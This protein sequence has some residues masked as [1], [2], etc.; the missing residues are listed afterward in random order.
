MMY[1]AT[2]GAWEWTL[3]TLYGVVLAGVVGRHVLCHLVVR[4]TTFLTPS[5]RGC[6]LRDAPKVSVLVP[7]KDEAANIGSC[8]NSLLA[9]HYPNFEVLVVDDRSTDETPAIVSGMAKRD[10]RLRLVRVKSLP[11]GW[12]GKCHALHFAQQMATGEWLLFIDADAT[13]HPDCLSVVLRDAIDADAGLASVLPRME[14]RSF[15]ERVVQPLAATFLM[16]LFPLPRVN[17]R[18]RSDYGFAN[19]QFLLMRRTAY[20]AIGGHEAVK[21][22][23]CEDINLGRLIKQKGLGL[24]VVVAPALASVRMYSSLSQIMRGW[25]RIF[26]AA[27]D[28]NAKYL[29]AFTAAFFLLSALPYLVIPICLAAILSGSAGPLAWTMLLMAIVHDVLQT[30]LYVRAFAAGQTPLRL[31]VWRPIAIGMMLAILLKTIR[32]CQ[33]HQVVWRGTQ[34]ATMSQKGLPAAVGERAK[35]A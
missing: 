17:D 2:L 34:Y 35:A 29:G 22:K 14:M 23:F 1:G 16:T 20:D 10:S 31:L 8:L 12:T 18:R 30:A 13:L 11:D 19:G 7:A 3:V 4:R 28:A 25:T 9:Q 6:N 26:Y 27:V 33:T 15:W 5:S 24:R 32:L 21:D